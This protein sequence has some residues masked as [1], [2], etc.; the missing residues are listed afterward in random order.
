M[1]TNGGVGQWCQEHA[2]VK[3][4]AIYDLEEEERIIG[5]KRGV[6][7]RISAYC[8]VSCL[9]SFLGWIDTLI[10]PQRR[11]IGSSIS[12]SSTKQKNCYVV[13]LLLV[14]TEFRVLFPRREEG[15]EAGRDKE[16]S[17]TR[18]TNPWE[19]LFYKQTGWFIEVLKVLPSCKSFVSGLEKNPE[20]DFFFL[21]R[22]RFSKTS[23]KP[24][25]VER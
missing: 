10:E 25:E 5:N 9:I 7:Y 2:A 21:L 15:E 20:K 19:R 4:I 24:E 6:S 11:V 12:L 3:L 14:E 17:Q 22:R 23:C 16:S 13:S 8:I 18:S 1:G